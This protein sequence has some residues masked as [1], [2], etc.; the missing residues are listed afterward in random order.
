MNIEQ[1]VKKA[2]DILKNGKSRINIPSLDASLIL[3]QVIDKDRIYIIAHSDKELS[4]EQ[5][6][7]YFENINKRA[8]GEPLAYITGVKQF[9]GLDFFVDN[10]VLIPRDDTEILVRCVLD[11][12]RTFNKPKILN[13]GTG[14]G[15][16]EAALAKYNK[17]SVIT[18]IEKY[19]KA[20]TVARRNVSHHKLDD[21]ITL[22]RSDM[23]VSVDKDNK[24]DIICSNPPYITKDEME[25]LD[26]DV[27][28]YEPH[29]ALYGGE[30]G[31]DFYKII[32][33]ESKQFLNPFG[34]IAVE[35]GYAQRQDAAEIFT[36][37]GYKN[38][39]CHKDLSNHDRVI[40]ANI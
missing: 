27:M 15:C 28:R 21:R 19:E 9:M 34:Y 31:L 16:V 3:C 26:I 38:I 2:A 35:I 29:T 40:T 10:S 30:N 11:F 13:I 20:L 8:D 24:Y 37:S 25:G 12:A 17:D 22:I 39:T 36:A 6:R 1:A 7:I 4:A 23:F 32:A 33:E 18:G 5:E 14:S